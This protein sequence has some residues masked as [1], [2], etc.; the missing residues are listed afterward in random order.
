MQEIRQALLIQR[1]RYEADEFSHLDALY[2]ATEGSAA[3][4]GR[5]D[6]GALKPGYKAD[7][8]LFSLDVI[9]R[10]AAVDTKPDRDTGGLQFFDPGNA[11][12]QNHVR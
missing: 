11:R 2:L 1:L 9:V 4:L 10:C 12:G 7:L 8:A 5:T 3:V 6:I